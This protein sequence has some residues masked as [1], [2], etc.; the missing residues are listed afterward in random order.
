MRAAILAGEHQNEVKTQML[1]R[2]ER[3]KLRLE[4][5]DRENVED[6]FIG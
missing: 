2:L 5:L 3:L 1:N 6:I 4:N